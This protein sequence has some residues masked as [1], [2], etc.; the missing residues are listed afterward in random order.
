MKL[1]RKQ[2]ALLV[3]QAVASMVLAGCGGVDE[4]TAASALSEPSLEGAELEQA[5]RLRWSMFDSVSPTVS[6]GGVGEVNASGLV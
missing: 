5:E 6:V 3:M 4:P 2:T 1:R